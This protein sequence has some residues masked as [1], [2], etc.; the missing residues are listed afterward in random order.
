MQISIERERWIKMKIIKIPHKTCVINCAWNGMEDQYE[1][2]TGERPPEYLFFCLSGM[3]DYSLY[4][5][6]KDMHISYWNNEF[7]KS[8][9]EFMED[10]VGYRIKL[11]E[12][13][14]F[15]ASLDTI[16]KYINN[17]IPV[18]LGALDMFNLP[19]FQW[20]YHKIHIPIHYIMAVGYDDEKRT[21]IIYDNDRDE[22][23]EVPYQ[24]LEDSWNMNVPFT[25]FTAEFNNPRSLQEIVNAGLSKK[26]ELI[27][28]SISNNNI[29][30][31]S[32]K[33]FGYNLLLWKERLYKEE[34]RRRMFHFVEYTGFPPLLP[35]E[36]LPYE[37]VND[38]VHMGARDVIS[39]VLIDV[40]Q[41]YNKP[42][43]K[44]SAEL[45]YESG[46]IIKEIT[47]DVTAFLLGRASITN[48]TKEKV[49][50]VA[51]KEEEAY[52]LILQD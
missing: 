22:P 24:D 6:Y 49:Y 7:T 42:Y 16:K 14:S 47:E 15:A 31:N 3:M 43:C 23:Q 27:L 34:Y 29:G 26:A 45:F 13:A 52:K 11:R 50:C 17:N 25:L 2:L 46:E 39:K 20:A 40:S 18:I 32:I 33:E 36:L 51:K 8:M 21:I 30:A 38:S 9:Y 10:I 1:W 12:E 44:Q 28:N 5:E 41:K 37:P 19:Y 48:T 4:S 35:K